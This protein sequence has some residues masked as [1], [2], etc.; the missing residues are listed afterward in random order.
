MNNMV[1]SLDDTGYSACFLRPETM[2]ERGQQRE[3]LTFLTPAA[4]WEP[5]T[6]LLSS[7][8]VF[9]FNM[10][11][12]KPAK[13]LGLVNF[14]SGF[15]LR[16]VTILKVCNLFTNS[17]WAIMLSLSSTPSLSPCL[18][19]APHSFRP[20]GFHIYSQQAM[21]GVTVGRLCQWPKI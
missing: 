4:Y 3:G 8:S 17:C 2:V 19:T 13:M 10:S 7:S 9:S 12:R 20:R 11:F 21:H 15:L 1:S 14:C 6:Q 16:Y 5:I 18:T